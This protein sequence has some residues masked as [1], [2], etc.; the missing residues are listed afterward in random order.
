MQVSTWS[1]RE[2]LSGSR[3]WWI[4]DIWRS[5]SAAPVTDV[6][7]D[8]FLVAASREV[9]NPY[10]RPPEFG[11]QFCQ[12]SI[13]A[14]CAAALRYFKHVQEGLGA[15]ANKT[16]RLKKKKKLISASGRSAFAMPRC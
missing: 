10:R 6:A 5:R 12:T 3:R 7:A 16:P 14:S 1:G 13:G 11:H 4:V 15:Q 9:A 2:S 8:L